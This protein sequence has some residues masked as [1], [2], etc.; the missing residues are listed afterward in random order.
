[1]I[2]I[3]CHGRELEPLL[4]L[5]SFDVQRTPEADGVLVPLFKASGLACRLG[6]GLGNKVLVSSAPDP[7]AC[8]MPFFLTRLLL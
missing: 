8:W 2:V 6:A 4:G 7:I 3:I 5:E 1:M